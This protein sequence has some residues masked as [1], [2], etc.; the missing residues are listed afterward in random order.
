MA[1]R[2]R[3]CAPHCFVSVFLFV[4]NAPKHGEVIKRLTAY[5]PH[6]SFPQSAQ[7]TMVAPRS[8]AGC[9]TLPCSLGFRLTSSATGGVRLL[10]SE[11]L[12]ELP[13]LLATVCSRSNCGWTEVPAQTVSS[14]RRLLSDAHSGR[15]SLA[16]LREVL[17][18][19][20][21]WLYVWRNGNAI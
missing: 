17:A 7:F 9:L 18:R 12:S 1:L 5:Q 20:L 14:P 15:N 10:P 21:S 19:P 6:G 3:F 2:G 13:P 4:L 11:V 8:L 16:P